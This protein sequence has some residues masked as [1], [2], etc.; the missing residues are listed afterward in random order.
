MHRSI[1]KLF[2]RL[3]MLSLLILLLGASSALAHDYPTDPYFGEAH[4]PLLFRSRTEQAQRRESSF[5]ASII[6]PQ[7]I[8]TGEEV[9][10]QVH[11]SGAM[12]EPCIYEY[13]ILSYDPHGEDV[14]G[15]PTLQYNYLMH[16][17]RKN[18]ITGEWTGLYST[19]PEFSFTFSSP[20]LY[21]FQVTITDA[22][23]EAVT[24]PSAFY[25]S[26][27]FEVTGEDLV[28]AR[29]DE[30]AALCM[31]KTYSDFSRAVWLHDWLIEHADYDNDYSRYAAEG[32]ILYGSGVCDS[33][34]HAYA[35][36][37]ER[38]GISASGVVSAHH[39]WNL[40]KLG[41]DWY[42]VDCTWDDPGTKASDD[43]ESHAFFGLPDYLIQTIRDHQPEIKPRYSCY[44]YRYN[45]AYKMEKLGLWQDDLLAE[46]ETRADAGEKSIAL[47]LDGKYDEGRRTMTYP[48]LFYGITA[49]DF[50]ERAWEIG[51]YPAEI[52]LRYAVSAPLQ[53]QIDLQYAHVDPSEMNV[54]TLPAALTA[55]EEGAFADTRVQ[56]LN[57]PEGCVSLGGQAFADCDGLREAYIPESVEEIAGDCFLNAGDFVLFTPAGSVAAAY[58]EEHHIR[59]QEE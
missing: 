19:E 52:T 59:L 12:E 51:G 1:G 56:V 23:G 5:T 53:M 48:V 58:A 38:V 9:T 20:G 31:E 10:F 6:Y 30:I 28:A 45:Y 2:R 42:N 32:V 36:L 11:L 43:A 27:R 46:I 16:N 7:N 50:R 37:L 40:V 8:V 41:G 33:Y 34:R 29:M 47:E 3:A 39:A 4:P 44:S 54:L 14:Y 24:I 35:D 22:K 15:K 25:H 21:Y 26:D 55:V 13:A 49:F 57:V 18:P 17:K